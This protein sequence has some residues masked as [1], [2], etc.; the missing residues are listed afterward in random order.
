M[1]I[2]IETTGNLIS[3][4]RRQNPAVLRKYLQLHQSI[5]T[6]VTTGCAVPSRPPA[7]HFLIDTGPDQE[8]IA[9]TPQG[10]G[11]EVLAGELQPEPND[12]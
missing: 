12:Q 5:G 6:E 4:S 3:R 11:A 8:T 1:I 2:V 9:A 10:K 7:R